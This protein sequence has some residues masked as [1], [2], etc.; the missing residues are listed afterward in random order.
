MYILKPC[1]CLVNKL[2][3][4]KR[5]FFHKINNDSFSQLNMIKYIRYQMY[6]TLLG[7]NISFKVFLRDR[8]LIA[9]NNIAIF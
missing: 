4:H 9:F 7:K 6:N 3:F 1:T 5:F 2:N 8:T